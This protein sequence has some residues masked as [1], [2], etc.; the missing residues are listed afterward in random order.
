MLKAN[1]KGT[2]KAFLPHQS[3]VGHPRRSLLCCRLFMIFIG[4]FLPECILLRLV[5]NLQPLVRQRDNG[6]SEKRTTFVLR[7]NSMTRIE[8]SMIALIL[9]EPPRSGQPLYSVQR[10]ITMPPTDKMWYKVP[11]RTD[12][13]HTY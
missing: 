12:R 4:H 11:P 5:V 13:N 9:N 8:F 6:H 1:F 3:I 10:T 2:S 7:T